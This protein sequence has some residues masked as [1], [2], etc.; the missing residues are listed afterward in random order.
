MDGPALSPALRKYAAPN[1]AAQQETDTLTGIKE[2][3]VAEYALSLLRD[4]VAADDLVQDCLERGICRIHLF[5]PGTN[6][7]A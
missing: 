2:D 4:S 1:A 6:L 3:I 5:Q 7:R